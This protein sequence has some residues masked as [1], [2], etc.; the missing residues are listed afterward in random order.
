M[1][2]ATTIRY[3][4]VEIQTLSGPHRSRIH[5]PTVRDADAHIAGAARP[6][7]VLIAS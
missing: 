6:R 7:L 4:N 1:R 3:V 2:V 5:T